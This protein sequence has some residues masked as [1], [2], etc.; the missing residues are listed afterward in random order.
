MQVRGGGKFGA[1]AKVLDS[2]NNYLRHF[3]AS[4]KSAKLELICGAQMM[5]LPRFRHPAMKSPVRHF[6]IYD[7]KLILLNKVVAAASALKTPP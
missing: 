2:G 1:G 4:T 7:T 3:Q 5:E 6:K